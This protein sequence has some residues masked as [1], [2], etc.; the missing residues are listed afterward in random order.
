MGT[1]SLFPCSKSAS[2]K[3][4]EVW[5]HGKLT[6]LDVGSHPRTLT[7]NG[8]LITHHDRVFTYSVDAGDRIYQGEEVGGPSAKPTHVVV[9]GPVEYRLDKDHLYIK[10]SDGK[11]HKLDLIKT[12]RKE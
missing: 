6:N 8:Q 3:E 10:D 11:S 2:A 1:D 9:N 12:T 7:Y 4:P 5:K